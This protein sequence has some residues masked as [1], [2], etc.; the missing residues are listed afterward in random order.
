[1]Q[2]AADPRVPELGRTQRRIEGKKNSIG[3]DG[4]RVSGG[5]NQQQTREDNTY[6]AGGNF[7]TFAEM[8]LHV[9]GCARNAR[10]GVV[11]HIIW[12]PREG[13]RLQ[14]HP[15]TDEPMD[16]CKATNIRHVY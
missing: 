15:P 3:S 13:I 9:Q 7:F 6:P 16:G 14:R 1:M 11:W 10:T 8:I 2:D 4:E 5:Y 12:D